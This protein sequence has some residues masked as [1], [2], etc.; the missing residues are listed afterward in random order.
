M[1]LCSWQV[2]GG[3]DLQWWEIWSAATLEEFIPYLAKTT[4][5]WVWAGL[6]APWDDL[7]SSLRFSMSTT[8]WLRTKCRGKLLRTSHKWIRPLWEKS[9]TCPIV[10]C[11]TS[12]STDGVSLLSLPEQHRLEAR[13]QQQAS[14][15]KVGD[16]VIVHED[17]VRRSFWRLGRVE[18]LI[19]GSAGVV[20]GVA[21]KVGERS[22]PSTVIERPVQKLYPLETHEPTSCNQEELSIAWSFAKPKGSGKGRTEHF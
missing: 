16:V 14:T 3:L 11:D 10:V 6:E 5:S 15:I 19:T 8:T 9:I 7:D 4:M 13:K 1:W 22:K 20:R 21:V 2:F 18:R 17:N 12:A